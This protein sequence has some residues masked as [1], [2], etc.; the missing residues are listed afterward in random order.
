MGNIAERIPLHKYVSDQLEA[1][2]TL[3]LSEKHL[4]QGLRLVDV[5]DTWAKQAHHSHAM[6][7]AT[8]RLSMRRFMSR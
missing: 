4:Y 3:L 6:V 7:R 8:P 2:L 1:K 5:D